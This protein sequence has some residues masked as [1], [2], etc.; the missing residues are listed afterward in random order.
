MARRSGSEQEPDAQG[1]SSVW[2]FQAPGLEPSTGLRKADMTVETA[3]DSMLTR[4]IKAHR[5]HKSVCPVGKYM[6]FLR[7]KVA[8]PCKFRDGCWVTSVSAHPPW[9][10]SG[11]QRP[12]F[13][14]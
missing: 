7:P 2:V 10:R 9:Y 14:P 13:V 5:T 11:S 1:E 3:E 4:C 8:F 12:L 6:S